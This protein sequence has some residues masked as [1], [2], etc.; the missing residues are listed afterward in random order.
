MADIKFEYPAEADVTITLAALATSSTRLVGRQSTAINNT[1]NKYLDY[2]VSGRI[3]TGTT[4]TTARSIEIWCVAALDNAAPTY[5]AGFGASDAA[6]P[7]LILEN[8]NNVC[9]LVWSMSTVATSDQ[10]YSFGAVSIAALF[11]GVCPPRFVFF[12]THD[13]GVN[14]NAT[15]GNH[16]LRLQ[17]IFE[18]VT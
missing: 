2:L 18:T 16:Q 11:N 17:P 14:L 1:V 5:L 6:G 8:K 15:T 4:P 9:K 7:T 10:A 3:M 13:T 12:V